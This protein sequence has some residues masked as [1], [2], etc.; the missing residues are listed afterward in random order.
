[1]SYIVLNNLHSPKDGQSIHIDI[2]P[3]LSK[4]GPESVSTI[5]ISSNKKGGYG[6]GAFYSCSLDRLLDESRLW[7]NPDIGDDFYQILLKY[8][9]RCEVWL[10]RKLESP[11]EEM[12]WEEVNKNP[13]GLNGLTYQWPVDHFRI[14]F[15]VP[16]LNIAIEL[17]GHEY[18][19]TKEQ[20]TND[21]KRE[22][23]L[24]ESGWT[25]I[26]FTGSEIFKDVEGCVNQTRRIIRGI[27]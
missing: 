1:M 24:Q 14:D 27:A 7:Y 20:R 9:K 3:P 10:N 25:V 8:L 17:D 2:L 5:T 4:D 19:K 21:A 15:A 13:E 18:H 11:I 22:R 26:R 12:F 6:S 16:H 23:Y